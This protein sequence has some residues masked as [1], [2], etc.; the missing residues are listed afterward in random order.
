MLRSLLILL[1]LANFG[2]WA[3]NR[4][5]VTVWHSPGIEPGREPARLKAQVN[6]QALRLLSAAEI[7]AQTAR[8]RQ[9]AASAAAASGAASGASAAE[10]ADASADTLICLQTAALT[11]DE[12]STLT[13]R[14]QEAG[15]SR[16]DWE[17]RRREFSGRWGVHLGPYEEREH[18]QRRIDTLRRLKIDHEELKAPPELTPG[19]LLGG[20]FNSEEEARKLLAELSKRGL[21]GAKVGVLRPPSVEHRL[22][23]D[24]L[25]APQ[26]AKVREAGSG[27][28]WRNCEE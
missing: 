3:W 27:L 28:R 13:T 1:I 6:A 21:R 9:A 12:F 4:P 20:R 24:A 14:L 22:R 10:T 5:E 19:L 2:Y 23:I 16:T 15:F 17:D 26:A 8:E 7:Q 18:M 25:T 11:E